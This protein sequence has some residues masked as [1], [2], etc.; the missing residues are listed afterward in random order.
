MLDRAWSGAKRRESR[1]SSRGRCRPLLESL[2]G[3][4]VLNASLAALPN[5]TSPQYIGFQVPLDGS[6]S[7]ST[8]QTYTV[9]SSNPDIG[10]T[11][12]QGQFITYNVTHSAGTTAGDISFSGP[13]T[14]Q[15]FNDLTPITANN[16]ETFT[17]QGFYN[18]KQL[19]RVAN[20]D[21][22]TTST[23]NGFIIQGGSSDNT[24]SGVSG[25]PGTP[26]A[27]EIVQQLGFTNAG[28][29]A[30]A[31][32]GQPNSND[33]QF[34]FTTGAP[35]SLDYNYTIF[36]QVVAGQSL[37]NQMTQVAGLSS[38]VTQPTNPITITTATT[39]S[40]NPN[41]VVHIDT[42]QAQVGET[43]TITVTATDPTTNTTAT[44]TFQVTVGQQDSSILPLNLRPIAFSSQQQY[45]AGQPQTIQLGA[46][47]ANSATSANQT[48][49]YTITS[50]PANGTLSTPTSTGSVVYT[51]NPGF[52]GTDSF[53]FTVTNSGAKLT[54]NPATV[55]L[56]TTAVPTITAGPVNQTIHYGFATAIQLAGSLQ[57]GSSSQALNYTLLSQ[58]TK[59][60]ISQ[61]NAATGSFV[62]TPTAFA[63]GTDTFQYQV[64]TV[65]DPNPGLTSPAATVTINLIQTP[66]NTGAV[67]QVGNVL[68]VTPRPGA[69]KGKNTIYIGETNNTTDSTQDLLYTFVNGQLD[70]LQPLASD[71]SS[72]QI[73][74]SKAGDYITVDP[75]VDPAI[76]VTASGGGGSLKHHNI[77][78]AGAGPTIENAWFGKN[79]L[80]GGTG[81][82]A[83]YARAG[84][85]KFR[86]TTATDVVFAGA[87]NGVGQD[88]KVNPPSGTFFRLNRRGKLVAVPT[89]KI[90][91]DR[92]DS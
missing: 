33:T 72:I 51:P 31:N 9:T 17:N 64:S 73:Y 34:F 43:S 16:I 80:I 82:N 36:G 71:I 32:T 88:G 15:A 45:T 47:P 44:Q 87:S 85:V 77:I 89:P 58:P 84:K 7:G 74:G 62:Y 37:V 52:D 22:G 29:I 83:L 53:K 86:P 39:S 75:S 14:V 18:T 50:P 67:R 81:Q 78:Q 3:R 63:Q 70:T 76:T 20:F 12:A 66:I 6:G 60:T 1:T 27:N 21:A 69:P 23:T 41:G 19:F 10:A 56:G 4:V 42:T 5:I 65:G 40:T 92:Q 30:M 91:A 13:V 2:E 54:S 24:A 11:V 55:T 57:N 25:L 46:D 35:T 68:V 28:Q 8:T 38:T 61:F 48:L 79:T 59:G 26:F 90:R 49:T